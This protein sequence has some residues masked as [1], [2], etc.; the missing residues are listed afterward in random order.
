MLAF[1]SSYTCAALKLIPRSLKCCITSAISVA[2]G[3]EKASRKGRNAAS[4]S[5]GTTW[6]P[7]VF[8]MS[9]AASLVRPK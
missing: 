1:T 7:Y 3:T 8:T 5:L 2:S 9:A 6:L 4:W